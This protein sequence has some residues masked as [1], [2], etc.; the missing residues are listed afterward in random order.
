MSRRRTLALIGGGTILAATGGVAWEVTRPLTDAV[1]PWDLAGSYPDPRMRA[2]S[3][4]ILA[5]NSH[6]LQPWKVDLSRPD[7]VVL[8]PD[9]DRLLP[10][11]DPF[12][13]QITISLGCFLELMRM[14]ALEDGL[15]VEAELFPEGADP[16]G[17]DGR[18]VAICRFR[19]T[20]EARDPL[21]A[22]A[23]IR[24]SN[25]EPYDM[26]RRVPTEALARIAAAARQTEVGVTDDPE[27]VAALR[28]ITVRA[29]EIEI[30]TPR[31]YA[32]SV[33]VFRIGRRE[34]EANPDGLEF[35]GP[36]FETMRLFG[37]F[38]REAAGNPESAAFAQGKTAVLGPIATAMA[39]IWQVTPDNSRETQIATGRD[40]LRINLA[41]VEEGIGFHPLSQGL[42]EYPEM[43]DVFAGLHDRLAPDG[44]T[45][46]MLGRLG[47][48]PEI[49]PTPRWPLEA[50]I[51]A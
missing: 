1:A 50:K 40:W 23:A 18:P 21:F 17:L 33:E 49:G 3:W 29:M 39:H 46:Q 30:D 26:A 25:K 12:N 35:H 22:Q 19:P 34:V 13:R 44:G 28:E 7:E 16:G 4:A 31:T 41:A 36:A 9:L 10:E 32:E 38:T 24:R 20:T 14:A 51:M 42:Q 47:Y 2:L 37:L 45:V 27:T 11:T 6:N 5:P 43:A 48:G 15:A 8:Y